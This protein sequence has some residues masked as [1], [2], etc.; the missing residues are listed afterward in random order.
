MNKTSNIIIAICLDA[1]DGLKL[2]ITKPC[3]YELVSKKGHEYDL[4]LHINEHR[5]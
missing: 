2:N 5:C 4:T 1:Y 3:Q